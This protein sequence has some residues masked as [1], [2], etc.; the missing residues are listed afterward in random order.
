MKSITAV[1]GFI[2]LAGCSSSLSSPP[3]RGSDTP[4]LRVVSDSI[5][6]R[7]TNTTGMP[8]GISAAP[9]LHPEIP[10]PSEGLVYL[11]LVGPGTSCLALPAKIDVI[12]TNVT[13]GQT[14]TI[15]WVASDSISIMAN[16]GTAYTSAFAPNSAAGWSITMPTKGTAPAPANPCIP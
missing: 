4:G 1:L 15:H 11:G 14:D 3:P 13:T 6:L 10:Q 12:V 7:V 9:R 5:T 8:L 2:A 16:S